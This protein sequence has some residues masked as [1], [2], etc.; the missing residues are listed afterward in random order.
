MFHVVAA[1]PAGTVFT[2]GTVAKAIGKPKASRA[3]GNALK[4]NPFNN[5]T[6]I[7]RVPCHRVVGKNHLGGFY[8]KQ[9]IAKKVQL[10]QSEG[11]HV[12]EGKVDPS[13]VLHSLTDY[14]AG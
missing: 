14:K 4:A 7:P 1:I 9:K 13:R 5:E 11:V 6:S 3:V 10:L 12:E 2:Y 8:G